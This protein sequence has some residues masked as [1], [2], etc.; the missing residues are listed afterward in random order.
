MDQNTSTI[1]SIPSIPSRPVR[2]RQRSILLSSFVI[3]DSIGER[4]SSD[5]NMKSTY[6][7]II[8]VILSEFHKR[9][10]ENNKVLLALSSADNFELSELQ[11]LEDLGI[12]L[13]SNCELRTAKKYVDAKKWEREK[14]NDARNANNEEELPRFNLLQTLFEVRESFPDVYNLYATIV[15]LRSVNVHFRHLAELMSHPG[16]QCL[17]KG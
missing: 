9:F 13:P 17:T 5:V 16:F 12:K 2:N 8:D 10:F 4:S 11:P 7:E 3:E 1:P 15:A 14:I 6:Y